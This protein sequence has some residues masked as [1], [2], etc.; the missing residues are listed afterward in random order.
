M[1]FGVGVVYKKLSS[2][3]KL[4]ENQL[5]ENDT[6]LTGINEILHLFSALIWVKFSVG[7]V[8]ENLLIYCKFHENW[9][10]ESHTSLRGNK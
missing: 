2:R 1:K 4:C 10:S 7:F 5:G 3:I 6:L 9:C 8:H